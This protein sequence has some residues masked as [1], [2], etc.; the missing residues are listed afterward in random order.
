MTSA[1]AGVFPILSILLLA[2]LPIPAQDG[3]EV[4]AA[5]P[6]ITPAAVQ[7]VDTLAEA[8]LGRLQPTFPAARRRPIRIELHRDAASLAPDLA[9]NLHPDTP[10]FALL[11]RDEIQFAL[12]VENGEHRGANGAY[13]GHVELTAQ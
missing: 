3:I 6:S 12:G 5:D 9:R 4:H 7:R 2:I 10:G 8:L 1:H 13:R 11:G